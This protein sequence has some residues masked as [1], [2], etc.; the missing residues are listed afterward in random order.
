MDRY[1]RLV[2]P[3]RIERRRRSIEPSGRAS[4]RRGAELEIAEVG[5]VR[6]VAV[7]GGL[8]RR[9]VPG[10]LH[11]ACGHTVQ[12]DRPELG[13]P[14][15]PLP[16]GPCEDVGAVGLST[17]V[18]ACCI[19]ANPALVDVG[20]YMTYQPKNALIG[21]FGSVPMLT[22]LLLPERRVPP[23]SHPCDT[24]DYGAVL[25]R[26]DVH[27]QR[28]LWSGFAGCR[29]RVA[30]LRHGW[31]RDGQDAG[32]CEGGQK[33]GDAPDTQHS[34]SSSGAILGGVEPTPSLRG[35]GLFFRCL[36]ETQRREVRE[37]EA[38]AS[39]RATRSGWSHNCGCAA[40]GASPLLRRES[41][42]RHPLFDPSP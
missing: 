34:S 12:P 7:P 39:V 29:V 26:D 22:T 13:V 36:C 30:V 11:P 4:P 3:A 10:P 38:S 40:R 23:M 6:G 41:A 5:A 8:A 16:E 18:Q 31:F 20:G 28:R 42:T 15:P 33:Y 2:R 32:C 37:R 27:R 19:V 14:V 17:G 35:R 21:N 9:D 25:V 24:A 1:H